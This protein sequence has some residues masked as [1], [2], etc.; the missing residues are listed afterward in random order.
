MTAKEYLRQLSRTEAFINA[1]KQRAEA[2]RRLAETSS[3]PVMNGMPRNPNGGGSTM[4]EAIC[5][6]IMIESEI[7][8]D[9]IALQER[10]VFLLELIG[11]I[12][13]TEHQTVLIKRYFEKLS[14]DRIAECM[15]YSTRWIYKLHGQALEDLEGVFK[16]ES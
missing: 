9:E 5:K 8:E 15:F 13:N 11:K 6:A 2:L 10:K 12:E 3:S 14:W 7:K 4:A 16:H 1:K